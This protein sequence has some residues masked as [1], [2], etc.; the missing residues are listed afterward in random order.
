MH[1]HTN[2][3]HA[4]IHTYCTRTYIVQ[5]HKFEYSEAQVAGHQTRLL[6]SNNRLDTEYNSHL[7]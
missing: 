6:K 2:N 7:Q 1:K 3:S 5:C 4:F